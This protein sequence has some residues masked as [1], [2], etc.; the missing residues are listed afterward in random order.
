MEI[1]LTTKEI[2]LDVPSIVIQNEIVKRD[3]IIQIVD[4]SNKNSTQ[5]F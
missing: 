2:M 4:P 3:P 5:N 1:D